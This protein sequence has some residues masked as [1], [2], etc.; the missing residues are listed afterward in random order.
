MRIKK[1]IVDT[2]KVCPPVYV[3]ASKLFHMMN[4]S[5][6]PGNPGATD[7]IYN[8]FKRAKEMNGGAIGDYYEFGL[9]RGYTFWAAQD[10][11]KKLGI[12]HVRFYGFDSF[13]GMPEIVGIDKANRE[14]YKGQF[15]CS[16]EKVTQNLTKHGVDWSRSE[17]FEG[18]YGDVLTE[19]LRKRRP[20][21]KAAVAFIDCDLY[22]STR[23]VLS[24]LRPYLAE[25]SIVIFD[26][27]STYGDN[28]ELGQ[29]KALADFLKAN[30][31]FDVNGLGSFPINGQSFEIHMKEGNR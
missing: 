2:L 24:W 25:G 21:R 27:W 7:A 5:F 13:K 18:F 23:D 15:A 30:P 19:E 22:F 6:K 26:N 29:R 31:Q 20:F 10:A 3:A 8:A 17:L 14:F 28:P 9:F 1:V 12:D 11:C 4:R 16:K